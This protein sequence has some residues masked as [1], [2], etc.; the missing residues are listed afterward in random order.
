MSDFRSVGVIGAGSWGTA[1]AA[2]AARKAERV[3]LWGRDAARME[4]MARTR[5]N[6]TYLPALELAGSIKPISDLRTA[7]QADVLLLVTPSAGLRAAA[8]ALAECGISKATPLVSCTKGIERGSG[9]RMSQILSELM[10]ENPVGVLSGPSHAEEV[11]L[12][13]PTALVLG[14]ERAELAEP[15][16]HLLNGPSFRTYTSPDVTGIEL[17]GAL[18]NIFAIAAG[19]CD[20]LGLGDNSKAALV[21]RA[22]VEL[23]RIGMEL[24][25]QRETFGGLS[26]MGDLM[27]TCFSR[28]SRNR[29]VGELLGQGRG[30]EEIKA[31]MKMVAEG[32]PTTR[33]VWELVQARNIRA[34]IVEQ[35]YAL[36]SESKS[37]REA[38]S[39]LLGRD[40]RPEV[41]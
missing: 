38:M 29:H 14:C 21:T 35:V 10:P 34:P 4:E 11:A 41:D 26:G 39:E 28:H 15:L 12:G 8:G 18:K 27:V 31:G 23:T 40:P 24:G 37:P 3:W 16:Q 6:T 2:V 17:G 19:A 32:V 1:L 7:A 20:G 30:L 13:M 25:G 36:L 5:R 33:S 9:L 22:L